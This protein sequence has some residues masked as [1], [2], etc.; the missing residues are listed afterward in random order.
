MKNIISFL[1]AESAYRV[2][3]VKLGINKTRFLFL[4]TDI[5]Q[6]PRPNEASWQKEHFLIE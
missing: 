6:Y 3:K 5:D 1:S 2:V 4:F